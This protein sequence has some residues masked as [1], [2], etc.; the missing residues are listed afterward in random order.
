MYPA[1]RHKEGAARR[2]LLLAMSEVDD[3]LADHTYLV[4]ERI[5]IAD[6]VLVCDLLMGFQ[7]VFDQSYRQNFPNVTRHFL[8]CVNHPAF[9]AVLGPI[10]LCVETRK[11]D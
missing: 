2:A 1:D 7:M 9:R 11:Y 8:T 6:I 5:T 4:G 3:H 10:D